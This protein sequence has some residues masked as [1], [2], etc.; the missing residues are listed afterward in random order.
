MCWSPWKFH[1]KL[2]IRHNPVVIYM[3]KINNRSTRT[4]CEI[5]SKLAIKTPERRKWRRTFEQ[6]NANWEWCSRLVNVNIPFSEAVTAYSTEISPNFLVWK[7]C[8]NAQ[9]SLFNGNRPKLFGNYVFP[10]SFHTRKVGKYLVFYVVRRCSLKYVS[11]KF[12]QNSQGNTCDRDSLIKYRFYQ[13]LYWKR[14]FDTDIC[15][16]FPN[17][18]SSTT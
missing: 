6:V 18:F 8:G 7:F 13:E 9:C 3:F 16:I 4:R 10:Q 12:L 15:D 11:W 17:T 1:W 5:C 14:D 2:I